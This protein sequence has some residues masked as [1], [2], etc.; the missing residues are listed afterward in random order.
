MCEGHIIVKD[1]FVSLTVFLLVVMIDDSCTGFVVM[2][3][4]L[5]TLLLSTHTAPVC[6]SAIHALLPILLKQN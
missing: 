3:E 1:E 2:K 6:F 4:R 5:V